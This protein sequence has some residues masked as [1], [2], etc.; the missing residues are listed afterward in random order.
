MSNN[1]D[2]Q[3]CALKK[4]DY[5]A[6]DEM[7]SFNRFVQRKNIFIFV[8]TGTFLTIYI[9]LPILAFFPILQQK[10]IGNITGVWIYSAGLFLMTIIVCT[11]YIRRAAVF[12]VQAKAVIDEYKQSQS[13]HA[14]SSER[15]EGGV[16]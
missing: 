2:Q 6:I 14:D 5:I 13:T 12:D 8:M 3:S 11:I 9:L 7:P 10:V 1:I 15:S 16:R 4:A